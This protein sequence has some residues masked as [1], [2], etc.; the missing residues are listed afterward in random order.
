MA[1]SPGAYS[2]VGKND[3]KTPKFLLVF[4]FLIDG[5]GFYVYMEDL[6]E[7]VTEDI[8]LSK[9]LRKKWKFTRQ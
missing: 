6:Q 3:S 4:L 9:S 2:L 8:G 1:P 7:V 5:V